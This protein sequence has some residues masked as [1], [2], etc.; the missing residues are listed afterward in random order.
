MSKRSRQTP[1]VDE[2]EAKRRHDLMDKAILNF[3]G[4]ADELETALG[5]FMVGRHVGWKVL[6]LI[7][8]K[9]TVAKYEALLGINVREEFPEIGPD[10]ERSMAWQ[11]SKS[12]SNFWK[13][14]SGEEKLPLDRDGRRSLE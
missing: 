9:K 11:L 2:V 8:S 3:K 7:H 1:S 12:I 13:V 5:M 14:V 6:Y 10:A 4:S